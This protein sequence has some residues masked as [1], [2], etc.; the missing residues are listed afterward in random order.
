[1]KKFFSLVM[2]FVLALNFIPS[3]SAKILEII[4]EGNPILR[5]KSVDVKEFDHN[6][7]ELLDDMSETMKHNKGC[8]LAAPQIKQNINV[9]IV[10]TGEGV[11]EYIN[12]TITEKIGEQKGIEGC[13]SIPGYMGIVKRPQTIRGFAY[14]RK[15]NRFK[16]TA[17]NFSAQAICH[18]YDHLKGILYTDTALI[19]L[20][21]TKANIF[22]GVILAMGVAICVG[23][24]KII[25]SIIL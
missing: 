2:I 3:P 18:E 15:G 20:S 1:M 5:N 9:F 8:G 24:V 11:K 12:P 14:D 13:L 7:S 6:L 22:S 10:D 25:S 21:N 19:K 16:F 17:S 4:R 23:I